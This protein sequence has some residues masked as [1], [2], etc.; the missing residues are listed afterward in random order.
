MEK[1]KVPEELLWDYK[2]EVDDILWKLQRIILF[3]PYYGT[4]PE[5]IN[6]LYKNKSKIKMEEGKLKLIKLYK[7]IYDKKDRKNKRK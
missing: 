5:T 4:D 2:E 7:E 6:L 1:L 3:F